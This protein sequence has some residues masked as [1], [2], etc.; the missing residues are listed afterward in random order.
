MLWFCSRQNSL[1][2]LRE[3]KT[4]DMNLV[5]PSE[6]VPFGW[7]LEISHLDDNSTTLNT[8]DDSDFNII[9]S[10]TQKIILKEIH[11]E[12][13]AVDKLMNEQMSLELEGLDDFTKELYGSLD[14][15]KDDREVTMNQ[16]FQKI[17]R[18]KQLGV[19]VDEAHHLFGTDLQTSLSDSTKETSL[20]YTIN[21][22]AKVLERN[23]T[24]LVACY[25]Y[26]GT[27][28]VENR[29]LPKS[30]ILMD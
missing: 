1:Q 3:I 8:I 17:I 21:Y 27:P 20:R 16:R 14:D 4:F 6:Y 11:K 2:S 26:T 28:Y 15:L 24:K 10:N 19:Y 12:K 25:N 7:Q 13:T 22:I 29:V 23:S 30:Y 9:V 18:L 5:I